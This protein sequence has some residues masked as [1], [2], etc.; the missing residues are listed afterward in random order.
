M[1]LTDA[2]IKN[3]NHQDRDQF[4]SMQGTEGLTLVVYKY[5]SKSK[6]W[7]YQ[8]RPRGKNPVR[9]KVGTYEELGITK[10]VSRAKKISNEIFSGKDPYAARQSFKGE[11]TLGEQIKESYNTVFTATRYRPSTITAIKNIFGIYIFRRTLNTNIREVFNQLDNIQHIKISSITNN[12]I[13]KFHQILGARTPRLANMFVEYLRMVFN[14]WISRGIT[15]N[16]PCLIKKEDKFEEKEYLDF[17]RE[18]ELD[19]VRSIIIN[20]DLKTGRFLESHYKKYKLSVVACALIAYQIFSSRRTRSE[21]SPMQWSMINDGL[22][23][24]L[25]LIRTKTSKKNQKTDFGMG[26]DELDVIRTIKK[27]RL[28]NPK[29]KF[30]YP[31]EDPRFDFVFPSAA[32]GRDLGH[33]RKAKSLFLTD[34]DKTWKKVLLLAGIKRNLKHY[35]TRHTHATQLLRATGNLKL[36]ADTLGITIKQASKYAKTQHEDVIEG[37]NKAFKQKVKEPLKNII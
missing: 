30:Y 6:T 26:E 7:F 15:N 5:P 25:K 11:N 22:V 31:P 23:P 3:I 1:K 9:L 32:Y 21:A 14:I 2:F 34:V 13:V 29:S 8:Y 18:D 12:Q 24:T 17:L 19:R 33:G 28:N 36:V 10:A 20:K 16:Q 35:A 37:K 27:D 4:F